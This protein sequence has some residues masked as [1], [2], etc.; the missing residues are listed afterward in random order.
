M[1]DPS[2]FGRLSFAPAAPTQG[3]LPSGRHRLGIAEERDVVLFVPSGLDDDDEAPVA[4]FVM[5]HGA[6]AFPK[7]CCRSSR[8]MRNSASFWCWRRIRVSHLGYRDR[9]QCR[10]TALIWI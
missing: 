6:G 2:L 5:F 10:E 3:R 9:R 4:L 1:F 8:S 7:R